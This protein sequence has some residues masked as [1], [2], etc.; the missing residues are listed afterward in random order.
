MAS[1]LAQ[2]LRLAGTTGSEPI[3]IEHVTPVKIVKPFDLVNSVQI[4][5]AEIG[6]DGYGGEFA[7]VT[8]GQPAQCAA[9]HRASGA[10]KEEPHA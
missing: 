5:L 10:A 6:G 1:G 4:A 7:R 8:P 3:G 9:D 2:P